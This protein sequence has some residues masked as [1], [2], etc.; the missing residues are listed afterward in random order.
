MGSL[1]KKK[2]ATEIVKKLRQQG[3]AAYFVGG[4]VRDML[5]G[6]A[7]KDFDITTSAK[8]HQI[9]KNFP[10]KTHPVGAQFGTM[11]LVQG[12]LPFQV[13][14]FR[15]KHAKYSLSL[16]E[17]LSLRDFTINGLAYDPLENKII[18]LVAAKKDI[19][20]KIIRAIGNPSSR[21]KEDPLRLL[22]AARLAACLGFRISQE[23]ERAIKKLAKNIKTVSKERIRDELSAMFTGV[24]PGRGLLLLD[25][26]DLLRYVLPQVYQ[27]KGVKQP[28]AFHPEG[29][30]FLHTLLMLKRLRNPSLVLVFACLFHDLGKPETYEEAERIRFSGHDRV[31]ARLSD[32]ILK[33]LRFSNQA[34]TDIVA[35]VEN[36]MRFM[37][38]PRMREATLKRLFARPTFETELKLHYLDCIASH[39][40]L[41]VFRFLRKKYRQFKKAPDIP[42]PILNGY[43]LIKLGFTPGPIFGKIHTQLVDLQME[44]K[45]RTK[46]EARAWVIKKWLK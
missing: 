20:Q 3:F 7:P 39:K 15:A 19:R 40:D 22:R 36:H 27:L 46:S 30:V 13:S 16:A 14:T 32:R 28:P 2:L 12:K 11:L 4:C 29:D 44:G 9:K 18:D 21:L 38:A 31:G 25:Q 37:E 10:R 34:R 26:L 8:P 17:D 23:T 1:D 33:S 42:R 43:E 6:K 5:M 41:S 24:Y 45:L 35:C